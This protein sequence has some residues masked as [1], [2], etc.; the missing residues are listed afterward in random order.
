MFLFVC[1]IGGKQNALV[2]ILKNN[3]KHFAKIACFRVHV[4]CP[5]VER[6]GRE[7]LKQSTAF[8]QA[9]LDLEV[10]TREVELERRKNRDLPHEIRLAEAHKAEALEAKVSYCPAVVSISWGGGRTSVVRS[11]GVGCGRFD[12]VSK[13]A[14]T[15]I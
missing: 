2:S 3:I 14:K 9:G 13:T 11:S 5:Q 8:E 1:S 7:L 4:V 15:K 12:I 6:L 10:L